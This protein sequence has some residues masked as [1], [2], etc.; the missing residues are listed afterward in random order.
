MAIQRKRKACKVDSK[1]KPASV[2]STEAGRAAVK[3]K[4]GT[5]DFLP[6]F[7]PQWLLEICLE[8]SQV[9]AT[10]QVLNNTS[11]ST[12]RQTPPVSEIGNVGSCSCHEKILEN[13]KNVQEMLHELLKQ[14]TSKVP[15]F[16]SQTPAFQLIIPLLL[17]T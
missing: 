14:S 5:L 12:S 11:I 17:W 1:G 6:P 3:R 13:Q 7:F 4:A 16:N 8:K 2:G 9:D 15:H 10:T